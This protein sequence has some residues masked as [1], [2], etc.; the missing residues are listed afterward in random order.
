[1]ATKQGM[2]KGVG[3][4]EKFSIVILGLCIATLLTVLVLRIY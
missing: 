2:W 3:T 1:M 4:S